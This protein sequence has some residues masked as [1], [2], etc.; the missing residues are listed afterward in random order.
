MQS[1]DEIRSLIKRLGLDDADYAVLTSDGD[2]NQLGRGDGRQRQARVL[3]TTQQMIISRTKDRSFGSARDFF[4]EDDSRTLRIWD[5]SFVV[6]QPVRI[7]LASIYGLISFLKGR[8]SYFADELIAF[9]RPLVVDAAG[10]LFPIPGSFKGRVGAALAEAGS[11]GGFDPAAK[12]TLESLQL[13]AGRSVRL[14]RHGG[15]KAHGAS[16]LTLIG[17]SRPIPDDFAPAIITDASGRV[18][19]TYSAWVGCAGNLIR[20]P[21]KTNLYSKVTF[22][23]WTE[24]SGTDA[25]ADSAIGR[26]IFREV[27]KVI[28][29]AAD[30]EWLLIGDKASAKIDVEG[31]VRRSVEAKANIKFLNWGRHHGTNAY[32]D[33]SHLMVIGSHFYDSLDY[34]AIAVAASGVSI[35]KLVPDELP[36]VG[37]SEYQHNMLQAVM[38]GN[39]RNAASGIAGECTV[40]VIASPKLDAPQLLEDTFPGCVVEEWLPRQVKLKGQGKQVVNYLT[41]FFGEGGGRKIAKKAVREALGIEP[42]QRLGAIIRGPL[43]T[44]AL[45]R[46]GIQADNNYFFVV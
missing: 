26:L 11:S 37:G 22:K 39:A 36:E 20:L 19:G 28:D 32:K 1:K 34:K 43:I 12:R 30:N 10:E 38:R 14:L 3:I 46:Q 29:S 44:E 27:A 7:P 9:L 18:R 5:E 16:G 35:D 33:I 24:K 41:T 40:Y 31:E 13:V 2:L 6:A 25:L 23:L 15:G 17:A 42:K 45:S 21:A 8:L 4:Y